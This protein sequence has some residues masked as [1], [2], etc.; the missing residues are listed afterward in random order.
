MFFLQ[1]SWFI[2]NFIQGCNIRLPRLST[3]W[4]APGA[5][6][7]DTSKTPTQGQKDTT[8]VFVS[9][10]MLYY[11]FT[12]SHAR[13][14]GQT[15]KE[16]VPLAYSPRGARPGVEASRRKLT[17]KCNRKRFTVAEVGIGSME[18]QKGI[19]LHVFPFFFNYFPH[20]PTLLS[21]PFLFDL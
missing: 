11:C 13:H 1:N 10:N 9:N 12:C 5:K 14:V 18:V 17:K 16:Q 4:S 2:L 3:D 21:F 8:C 6:G 15:C 7:C 20:F 19:H